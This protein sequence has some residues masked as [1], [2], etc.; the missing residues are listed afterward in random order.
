MASQRPL[1]Q[2]LGI[3]MTFI[4]VIPLLMVALLLW[5]LALPRI[6]EGISV[7]HQV[8]AGSISGRISTL[9][10]GAEHELESLGTYIETR[11]V[12][13]QEYWCNLLDSHVGEGEIFEVV[14]LSDEGER[15]EA[16]GLPVSQNYKRE[17]MLGLDLSLRPFFRRVKTGYAST[18]SETFLST[19]SGRLA[20]ALLIPVEDRVLIGEITIEHLSEFIS[21][22]FGGSALLIMIVDGDG[23]AIADSQNVYSGQSLDTSQIPVLRQQSPGEAVSATAQVFF[24]DHEYIGTAVTVGKL[25]W[26]VL[27]AQPSREAFQDLTETFWFVAAAVVIALVLAVVA[28]LTIGFLVALVQ[29]LYHTGAGDSRRELRPAMARVD[30]SRIFRTGRPSA[31]HGCGNPGAGEGIVGK[32]GEIPAG[33]Q[34]CPGHH[35]PDR[36][37]WND[38]PHRGEGA[39]GHGHETGGRRGKIVVRPVPV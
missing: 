14:Y 18:W 19:I 29:A 27:V 3:Q 7:R 39:G 12:Q 16:V 6:H 36:P 10:A 26:R 37:R 38:R 23:R 5:Q 17:D 2:L 31:D 15:V 20:I 13:S 8:L 32:R 1:G 4:A 30:H 28:S 25:G 22:K 35:R 11:G 34:Q 24:A 33:G 9:L 21:F